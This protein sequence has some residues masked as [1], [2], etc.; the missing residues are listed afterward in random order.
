MS[1]GSHRS[2][3]TV[4]DD[5]DA[6]KGLLKGK[7]HEERSDM[8]VFECI[9]PSDFNFKRKAEKSSDSQLSKLLSEK[10]AQNKI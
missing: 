3:Q 5:R 8:Q 6:T 7:S 9:R 1:G 4:L 10:I 2:L